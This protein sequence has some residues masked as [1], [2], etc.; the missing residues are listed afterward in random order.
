M[1]TRDRRKDY[2][3]LRKA[4]DELPL[5]GGEIRRFVEEWLTKSMVHSPDRGAGMQAS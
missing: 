4:D 3:C 2:L 5:I 1:G